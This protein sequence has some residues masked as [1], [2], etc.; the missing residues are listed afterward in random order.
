MQIE[1]RVGEKGFKSEKSEMNYDSIIK[2]MPEDDFGDMNLLG[3]VLFYKT[4]CNL[5]NFF[6]L[7]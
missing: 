4:V 7:F 1:K 3:Y 5:I 6:L 2:P